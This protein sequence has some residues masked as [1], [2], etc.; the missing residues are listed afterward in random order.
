MKVIKAVLNDAIKDG[1]IL[2]NP[3]RNI[4]SVKVTEKATETHHRALTSQEQAL[5]M[6]ELKNDFYYPYIALMLASGM[7]SGE[8]GA[9]TWEDID[10]KNNVIHITKTITRDSNGK[11]VIGQ[12]PK[13]DS[14]YRDIPLTDTIKKILGEHKEKSGILPFKTNLIFST[15]NGNIMDNG[16]INRAIKNT[17]VRLDKK[18]IHIEHFTSHALRDTFATRYIEQ[19]GNMKT[20]QKLLGHGSITITMDLYAHVLPD[21]MQEEMQKINIAI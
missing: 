18:G 12:S 20:L 7:R 6:Q 11:N 15:V 9:L 1:I 19:G 10:T 17:L 2:D 21:T 13:T 3:S 8:V 5:F 16:I 4:K 14:G